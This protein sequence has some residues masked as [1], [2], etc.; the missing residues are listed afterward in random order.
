MFAKNLFITILDGR[1]IE[2]LAGEGARVY[3]FAIRRVYIL[4]NLRRGDYSIYGE[5]CIR[6]C[7]ESASLLYTLFLFTR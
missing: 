5:G 1:G 6:R 2:A 3:F 4:L 7:I